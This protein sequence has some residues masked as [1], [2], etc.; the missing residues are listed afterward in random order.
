MRAVW[1]R[2]ITKIYFQVTF[3][4]HTVIS[5][6]KVAMFVGTILGLINYGDR[7]FLTYDIRAPDWIKIIITYAVTYCVSTHG[8][9]TYATKRTKIKKNGTSI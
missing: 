2:L 9:V 1:V 6:A 8:A 3:G 7:I 4:R 5:S